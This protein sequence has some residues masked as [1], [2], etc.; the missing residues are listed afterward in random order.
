MVYSKLQ[1]WDS[2]CCNSNTLRFNPD[3]LREI[4]MLKV[5]QSFLF[6]VWFSGFVKHKN[7]D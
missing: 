7:F 6:I 3:S 1:L 5:G 2:E 4:T